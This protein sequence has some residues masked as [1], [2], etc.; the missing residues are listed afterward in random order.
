MALTKYCC[1]YTLDV[2]V[3]LIGFLHLNAGLYFWARASTFEPIYMWIDILIAA[4]Y[5]I[6]TTYFFLMLAQEA[7]IQSRTDYSDWNKLTAYGLGVCGFAICTLKWLEWSHP[8]TWSLV[9]WALVGLFN[10]YHWQVLEDY[11]AQTGTVPSSYVEL[12]GGEDDAK[13]S[14]E[15]NNFLA[16][17]KME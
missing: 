8:P 5:T 7:S 2:G 1:C 15:T 14:E 11:S 3:T 10:Y 6:R 13:V 17:N 12:V 16:V 9:A 4:M